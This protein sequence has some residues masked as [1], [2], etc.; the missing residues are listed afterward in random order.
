MKVFQGK[1]IPVDPDRPEPFVIQRAAEVIRRSGVVVVPTETLY[2]LAANAFDEDA[3]SRIYEIKGRDCNNPVLL[4]IGKIEDLTPLVLS[5]PK[6][7]QVIMDSL[8]PGHV[9]LVFEASK[10]VSPRLTGG[11]GK[12]GIRLCSHPVAS[13][14][15][16][17]VGGAITGTSANLSG[18]GGCADAR[19]LD[20]QLIK[21]V[22]LVLDCGMSG[23]GIPS[24]VIDVTVDPPKV[25]RQGAV[26]VASVK[27]ITLL[28]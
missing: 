1:V 19:E 21:R 5:V 26:G 10:I 22:D 6:T 2:G 25:L 24:T 18:K 9:T 8:W 3:V 20:S 12:I 17:A 16:K 13:Q 28:R 7:A 4:L 14:L 11:S 15:A 27:Q 23:E